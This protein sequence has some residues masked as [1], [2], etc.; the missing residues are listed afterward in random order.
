MAEFQ[1]NDFLSRKGTFPKGGSN[2][3]N[4]TDC[5]LIFHVRCR[6]SILQPKMNILIHVIVSFIYSNYCVG[7]GY[8]GFLF[9]LHWML[10]FITR[11]RDSQRKKERKHRRNWIFRSTVFLFFRR[12]HFNQNEITK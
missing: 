7:Q 2:D 5:E 11:Y 1:S 6:V 9:P 12:A 4:Y 8:P 3:P 10:H